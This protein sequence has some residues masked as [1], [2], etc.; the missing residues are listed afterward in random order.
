M[1]DKI[2]YGGQAVMEGVMM[3]GQKTAATAVRR[4]NG[5]IIVRNN[6][7][8]KIYTGRLRKT[9]FI[10]GIIVLIESLLLGL[11][12]LLYSANIALEEE[13][14]KISGGS[15]WFIM[16]FA[17]VFAVGLFFLAPL[18]LTNLVGNYI[19]SSLIFHLIEGVIRLAIF[20]L[21]LWLISLMKD[22][23][24]TYE[25]HGAEHKTINAY[26]NGEPLE[27]ESVSKYGTAHA[28]CGT[29]FLLS[30]VL[31][32]ILVFAL[33]GKQE[34][35]IMILSRILLLPVIAAIGYEFTQFGARHS[36]KAIMRAMIA[37]GLWLQK[38]TTREPDNSQIEVAIAAL[39]EVL[40][41][42]QDPVQQTGN[43]VTNP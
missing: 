3:R 23:R 37:P 42:D 39:K 18:F 2:R 28:R 9:P 16:I 10:R 25:Y 4:P 5:K 29:A 21:Y 14:E 34:T 6:L 33:V 11:N 13:D 19:E 35:W 32:A 36:D 20:L 26:E 17:M 24:R 22:I 8:S 15:V 31:I 30:V 38:L 12:S 27:V 41:T 7:L 1:A 40:A 43:T